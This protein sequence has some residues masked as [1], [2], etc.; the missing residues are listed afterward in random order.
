MRAHE[1]EEGEQRAILAPG[2]VLL[3]KGGE[4]FH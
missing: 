1:V 4:I 2:P 3:D